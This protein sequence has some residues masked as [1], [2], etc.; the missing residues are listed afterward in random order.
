M[1]GGGGQGSDKEGGMI[2][3]YHGVSRIFDGY[4]AGIGLGVLLVIILVAIILASDDSVTALIRNFGIFFIVVGVI[5]FPF[6]LFFMY[7]GFTYLAMADKERYG[8]GVF[9]AIGS[10]TLSLALIPEGAS[11]LV[12]RASYSTF[13]VMAVATIIIGFVF[14]L[15]MYVALYRLGDYFSVGYLTGGIIISLF[16][17]VLSA[18]P[19]IEIIGGAF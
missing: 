4:I 5:G 2:Y 14:E 16:A 15:L 13:L 7:R 10:L 18:I 1:A 8:I 11:L 9:G 19:V 12:L 6:I 3:L 17:T